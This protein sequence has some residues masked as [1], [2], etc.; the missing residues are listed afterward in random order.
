MKHV[1]ET[2][3][4]KFCEMILLTLGILGNNINRSLKT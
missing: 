3:R 2:N 1:D 4:E